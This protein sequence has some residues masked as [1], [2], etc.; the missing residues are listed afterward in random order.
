MTQT[1]PMLACRIIAKSF[2]CEAAIN[3][4]KACVRDDDLCG[5]SFSL[6][7]TSVCTA[8][9]GKFVISPRPNRSSLVALSTKNCKYLIKSNLINYPKRWRKS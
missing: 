5:A 3:W 4:A 2:L 8:G 6:L 7:E 9:G 1:F